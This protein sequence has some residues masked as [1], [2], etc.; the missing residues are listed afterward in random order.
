LQRFFI[1]FDLGFEFVDVVGLG[2]RGGTKQQSDGGE[3][4]SSI[5]H[6]IVT[7]LEAGRCSRVVGRPILAAAAFQAAL[8]DHRTSLPESRLQPRLAALHDA[9]GGIN[10]R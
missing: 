2:E 8:A 9:A 3:F 10:L 7:K 6:S 5:L 1:A 4:H